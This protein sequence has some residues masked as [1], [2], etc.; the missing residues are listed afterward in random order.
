VA[1][2]ETSPLMVALDSSYGEGDPAV[3]AGA[4]TVSWYQADGNYVAV[5]S[6]DGIGELPALCPGNSLALPDGSYDYISNAPT[7][8]GGCEGVDTTEVTEVIVCDTA[9]IFPT[10]IP[11]DGEG[12]VYA[13][14]SSPGTTAGVLGFAA[15][16]P[17][18]PEID[19]TAT[20][21]EVA[22]GALVGDATELT[23]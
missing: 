20:S 15:A 23:C 8:D 6:G 10:L 18:V 1:S 13:S 12:E 21:F 22:S 4:V 2:I 5:Y 17:S 11:S 3:E 14:I 16:D 7:A 9:W 19:P